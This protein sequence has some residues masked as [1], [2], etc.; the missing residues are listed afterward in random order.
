M[1]KLCYVCVRYKIHL[2]YS[3]KNPP[4]LAFHANMT[5][6]LPDA[7]TGF[8]SEIT[9]L[10]GRKLVIKRDEV[11]WPG[12]KLR[13]KNEGMPDYRDNT[14]VGNLVLTTSWK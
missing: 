10:D 13:I 11:T 9:Q 1:L 14:R 7:L 2:C 8:R 5:I 4:K 3:L 6:G 12:M